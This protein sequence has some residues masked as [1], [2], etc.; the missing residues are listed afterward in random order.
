VRGRALISSPKILPFWRV[1]H[2]DRRRL[3]ERRSRTAIA[4]LNRTIRFH[5]LESGGVDRTL[6]LDEPFDRDRDELVPC[7]VGHVIALTKGA[8]SELILLDIRSGAVRHR[9]QLMPGTTTR[10]IPWRFHS[11]GGRLPQPVGMVKS[12]PGMRGRVADSD[13]SGGMRRGSQDD[14]ACTWL[15]TRM[16]SAW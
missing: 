15:T 8:R 12:R 13:N 7:P 14:G 5:G 11:M 4:G 1:G 9:F 6:L 3:S 10:C 2:I 16:V